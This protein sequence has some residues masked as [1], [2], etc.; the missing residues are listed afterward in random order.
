MSLWAS[1]WANKLIRYEAFSTRTLLL[2]VDATHIRIRF[3]FNIFYVPSP[4]SY[5]SI[6][7]L[8]CYKTFTSFWSLTDDVLLEIVLRFEKALG[9]R[10]DEK[11]I[12][13]DCVLMSNN[14]NL[15]CGS[16]GRKIWAISFSTCVSAFVSRCRE[17][18]PQFFVIDL[19]RYS[20]LPE[21]PLSH[22]KIYRS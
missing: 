11:N 8:W 2:P 14:I 22:D 9:R 16:N 17:N 19:K 21:L 7:S 12:H 15:Q 10:S 5:I 4:A 13:L 6:C 3:K 20:K 1:S 18:F